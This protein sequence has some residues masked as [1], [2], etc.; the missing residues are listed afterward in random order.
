MTNVGMFSEVN[1]SIELKKLRKELKKIKADKERGDNDLE[2]T[3]DIFKTDN[4][5]KDWHITKLKDEIK[6]LKIQLEKIKQ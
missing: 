1:D 5:I 3:I 2:K 6:E 4:N